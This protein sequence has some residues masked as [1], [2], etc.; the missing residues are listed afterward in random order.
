M[1]ITEN[2]LTFMFIY[3]S[4]VGYLCTSKGYSRYK[5]GKREKHLKI[6]PHTAS[7]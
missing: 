2:L 5:Q 1:L 3:D 7:L 4:G 6:G